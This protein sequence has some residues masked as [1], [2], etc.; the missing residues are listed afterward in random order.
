MNLAVGE[1]HVQFSGLGNPRLVRTM[2]VGHKMTL[3]AQTKLKG[4]MK[5]MRD[6]LFLVLAAFYMIIL[7]NSSDKGSAATYKTRQNMRGRGSCC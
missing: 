6:G 4:F 1:P 5:E 3:C 2:V 7:A